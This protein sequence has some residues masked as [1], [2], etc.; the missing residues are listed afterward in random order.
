MGDVTSWY[1]GGGDRICF[2]G[3]MFATRWGY[4][5]NEIT[6][7]SASVT[8]RR[9]ENSELTCNLSSSNNYFIPCILKQTINDSVSY[10]LALKFNQPQGGYVITFIGFTYNVSQIEVISYPES[11][12]LPDGYE[13]VI[14][15]SRDYKN[16]TMVLGVGTS[17]SACYTYDS[18]K[19]LEDRI[20]AL[21]NK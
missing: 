9:H 11:Q 3:F 7:V 16:N 4:S 5:I 15:G 6:E 19:A 21:E 1:S 8:Y 13:M 2:A 20:T 10:K 12:D 18:I 14:E 17:K